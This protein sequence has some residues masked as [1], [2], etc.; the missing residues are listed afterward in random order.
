MNIAIIGAGTVGVLSVCH[1]L[2]YADNTKITCIHNPQKNILGIGESSTINMPLLLWETLNFN[3]EFDGQDLQY[4]F[5]TGVQFKNWRKH[6]FVSPIIPPKYAIHFD[7]F[8]LAEVIYK[9]IYDKYENRFRELNIDISSIK[10]NDEE[11][12][13]NNNYKFD[14]V[15][16]CRGFP[17]DYTNYTMVDLPINHCLVH[18][19]NKPGDWNFTYHIAHENGWMFGIPLQK[20]QGWG[21]LYN[22]NITT[23]KEAIDNFNI[24][25]KKNINYEDIREFTFKPF[26]ANKFIDGRILKNGNSALF[27]EPIEAI[28]GGFYDNLN[29]Y[30]F[31]YI[32][33]KSFSET[34]V[35]FHI[36]DLADRYLNFISYIYQG[37]S[38]YDSDFWN[39]AKNICSQNLRNNKWLETIESIKQEK[40]DA[41]RWPFSPEAW[42]ILDK[43]LYKGT[44]FAC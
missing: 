26:K 24:I 25:T 11:V 9:K 30:F 5:K 31:D 10:Q 32:F 36:H 39:Y 23:K 14:Y 41:S 8:K 16:D 2:G 29:R 42:N 44:T 3:V 34:A 43:N 27:Y 18:G 35:N 33:N 7:N 40:E 19:V 13:I 21:Y 17:K 6:D 1:F 22:D 4:T 38:I 15:I 12:I 20:R 37:G 28:S